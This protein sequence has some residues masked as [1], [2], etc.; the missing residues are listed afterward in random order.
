MTFTFPVFYARYDSV[1]SACLQKDDQFHLHRVVC[2]SVCL[3][4]SH[5]VRTPAITVKLHPTP[6]MK[7]MKQMDATHLTVKM[8]QYLVVLVY[9]NLK[10]HGQDVTCRKSA[11]TRCFTLAARPHKTFVT[12]SQR[13]SCWPAL[14]TQEN[15]TWQFK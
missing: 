12:C 4:L 9:R 3:S 8:T 5:H 6:E 10:I 13:A 1:Y 11:S 2:L 7:H 14:W 15:S